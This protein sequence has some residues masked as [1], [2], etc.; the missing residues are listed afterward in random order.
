M[1]RLLN[2]NGHLKVY[3]N[4]SYAA[5]TVYH[6]QSG[7]MRVINFKNLVAILVALFTS[8]V[9]HSTDDDYR[10]TINRVSLAQGDFGQEFENLK[11]RYVGK[12]FTV[13]RR[14]GLM[15]GTLKNSYGTD[16]QVIDHGSKDNSYKVVTT[17]KI[18]EGTGYGSNVHVLIISEYEK[19]PKKPFV[20]LCNE[21]VYFRYCEHF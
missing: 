5:D 4:S 20:H 19:A 15:A 14:T 13:E 9:A 7:A 21:E 6:L 17:M 12:E 1:H 18:E 3:L 2:F 10:C 16:P 8:G 11:K